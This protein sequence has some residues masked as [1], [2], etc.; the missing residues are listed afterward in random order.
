MSTKNELEFRV[1]VT[2]DGLAPL[3]AKLDKVDQATEDLGKSAVSTGQQMGG[4]GKTADPALDTV[5]RRGRKA[6]DG[7][8]SIS[9]QLQRVQNALISI[10]VG[11]SFLNMIKGAAQTADEYNNLAARVRLVTGEG[12]A[13]EQGME[14]IARVALATHAS[15]EATGTLFTRLAE[16]GKSAGLNTEQAA[17]QALALSETINQAVQLSGSSAQASDAALTQLIQGLQGGVLRGEEFNSVMEQSPRLARALA[18]GLGVTTGKLREMA[19]EGR[20]SSAVVIDALKSQAQAL[21]GEFET[22]PPTVGRAVQDL[23]TAW[24]I[25]IGETDKATGASKLAAQAIDALAKNLATVAGYLVDAGQ[26]AAAFVALRLAQ[27]FLGIGSAATSSAVAIGANTAALNAASVAGAGA[28]AN[29]G[30]FAAIV[31]GI[32]TFGLLAIIT[33]FRDIGTWIGEAAARLAGYKDRSE[34]LAKAERDRTIVLTEQRRAVEAQQVAYKAATERQFELGEAAQRAIGKF[35]DLVKGGKSAADAVAEIGKDIDLA[36][37][38]GIAAA[39]AVLDKLVADGKLSAAQFAAAWASALKGEDL[40]A[41]EVKARAALAG[42]TREAERLTAV[43]DATLR[44]AVRRS[45]ADFDVLAGGMGRAARSA[46]NDTDT[47]IAGLDRLRAQGVDVAKALEAS[48]SAAIKTADSQRAVD[49]LRERIEAMRETLG[50]RVADGLL[51]QLQDQAAKAAGA[52]GELG[53]ALRQ[54]GI[55]SDTELLKAAGNA[56]RLYEEVVRTGGS[57]REQAL[58]FEKFAQAATASGDQSAQAMVRARAAAHGFDTAIDAAGKTVVRRMG[59][60]QQATDAVAGAADRA[61]DGYRGMAKAADAAA[62][63]AQAASEDKYGRP[64][65]E[66]IVGDSRE[67]RLAG[68]NAVDNTLLFALEAKLRAGSLGVGDSADI[69][70]VIAAL[71][72]NDRIDRD[73]DRINPAAFS[74]Q[75]LVDRSRWRVVREQLDAA[76]RGIAGQGAGTPTPAGTTHTVTINLAGRAPVQIG[77]ASARDA[78]ALTAW[79]RELQDAAAR[80]SG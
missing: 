57:A 62:Q 23:N 47:I 76:R 14:G 58:A 17:E 2:D 11:D 67:E 35:D 4:I 64:K 50:K 27:T 25:Y 72:Q 65:G 68:Q 49:A 28:A 18:D 39:A 1:R 61:A 66:R 43:M 9:A 56:Q 59:E 48:L 60:A 80:T 71:D 29:V 33:N 15:L 24:T 10:G 70:A 7:I 44:E 32:K 26:A 54:L 73:L 8:E 46:I 31:G 22:L 38:P 51:Q 74:A 45:G 36:S 42:A 13:F 19:N 63:A 21:K 53:D 20:L 3:A 30:R 77:T 52:I 79:L 5:Y 16:A 78:Q 40:Q 6:A 12:K 41:F 69:D 37:Q 34:E 55:T 75:G